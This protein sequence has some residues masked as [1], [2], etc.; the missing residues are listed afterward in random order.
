[1]IIPRIR[2]RKIMIKMMRKIMKIMTRIKRMRLV[3][4]RMRIVPTNQNAD[5]MFN[6]ISDIKHFHI[7]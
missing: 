5:E 4:M 1:M 3:R 6:V 7:I 2:I